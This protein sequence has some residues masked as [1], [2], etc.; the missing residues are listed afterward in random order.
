MKNTHIIKEAIYEIIPAD[1][2]EQIIIFG[3]HAR[4][5]A[6]DD[7]D[8]DICKKHFSVLH[9]LYAYRPQNKFAVEMLAGLW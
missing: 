7:S 9:S 2:I 6:T 3:S 5:E 8:T 1:L 4:S